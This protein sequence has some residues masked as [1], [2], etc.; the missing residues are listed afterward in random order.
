MRTTSLSLLGAAALVCLLGCAN[1]QFT[2]EVDQGFHI[3]SNLTVAPDPRLDRIVIM[4]GF[5]PIDPGLH[6]RAALAELETRGFKPVPAGEADLWLAVFVLAEA[7]PG[8]RNPERSKAPKQE[9]SGEGHHGGGHG[10][11]GTPGPGKEGV[12]RG[13][14]WVS[15][16]R[17]TLIVQLHDRKTGL[18]VWQGEAKLEGK[19]RAPDGGPITPDVAIRQLLEPLPSHL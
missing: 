3:S 5:R 17:L 18:P 4:D 2:Y 14:G 9:G 13:S 15:K 16:G 7:P 6:Q 19:D 12:A 8:E 10:A 1:P 11:A